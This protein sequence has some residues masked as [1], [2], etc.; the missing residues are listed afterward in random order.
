[1][2]DRSR[3]MDEQ[4]SQVAVAVFRDSNQPGFATSRDLTRHEA[5]LERVLFNLGHIRRPGSSWRIRP[6]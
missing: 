5:E 1:M 2:E 3:T 4:L 6:S